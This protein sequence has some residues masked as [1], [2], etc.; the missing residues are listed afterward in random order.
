MTIP[1]V[2]VVMSVYNGEEYVCKAI[3]GILG[4][5]YKDIEF[6][7]I[8]DGSTDDTR[9]LL[10]NYNDL[11]IKVTWNSKREGL[12]KALN[13]GIQMA[14]GEYIARQDAD[15]ISMYDRL[16]KQVNYL[17]RNQEIALLGT[18][19]KVID[20][21][22]NHLQDIEYPLRHPFICQALK[23]Y[24]CF[25]HGSVV[26][27]KRCFD[28][29][30]GY[31]E[32]FTTAQDY[33]LWLRLSEKYQVANLPDRL[34]KYRFTPSSLTFRK[35][36]DQTRMAAF[37]RKAVLIRDE[38]LSE[39]SLMNQMHTYLDSPIT[40]SEKKDITQSYRPWGQLLL[41]HNRKNEAFLLMSEV[42]KYHPSTLHK[43]VY[44]MTKRWR[45]S[46][47]L[48]QLIKS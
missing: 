28:E 41:K 33:D 17:E 18:A 9:L 29:I 39:A 44:K 34:Y 42:F 11:R 35:I 27:R 14:S 5:S 2:S 46:F 13:K 37:A 45:S 22:G 8:D 38:G 36:F 47:I 10:Q 12:T 25:C 43:L 40:L 6:V 19:V 20:S 24:N 4:Q 23:K 32:A 16:E 31:R 26:F 15:D 3:D 1:R 21:E 30:E 7:I 48:E